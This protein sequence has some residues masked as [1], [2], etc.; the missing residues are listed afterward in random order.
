MKSELITEQQ[1][2]NAQE[3]YA[4]F[5]VD[6]NL[7]LKNLA[8][9]PISIHCWQGDDVAGFE[10][11]NDTNVDSSIQTT[12][13]YPGRARNI[14]E[15][16]KDFELALKLIPGKHRLNLHASYLENNGKAVARNEIDIKH[17]AG[18]ADWGKGK[19]AGI[20]FNPTFFGHPKAIDGFTLSHPNKAIRQFWIEHGI[21]CRKIAAAFGKEFGTTTVNNFWVPDGFKDIPVDRYSPRARLADSLDTIFKEEYSQDLCLDSVESKLFGVGLESFTVGSHEFY[22]GYAMSRGK[23]L[24]LDSGHFHPT[25]MISEK[26]SALMQFLP[27]LL[28]HVSR[29][30]RWDSD[31]VII[32][33]DELIEIA[34]EI[35]RSGKIKNIHIG[36]DFFDASINRIAAWVIGTRNMIKALLYALLE[37]NQLLIE[38]ENSFDYTSRLA[39][40]EESKT[41]PFNVIWNYYCQQAE[42][43]VG[44]EWLNTVKTYEK[45]ILSKRD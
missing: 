23:M 4:N 45:E 34:C 24:C 29:P 36:L 33:N 9:I 17:F 40:K 3:Q 14:E 1:Y 20:D 28:L 10:N 16:R 42:A 25:E 39:L 7:A 26:I 5:G 37:P 35:I 30:V 31:H 2:Q 11:R 22:M 12:G 15:L 6:T 8:S 43:P 19:I 21:A 38:K 32:L 13:D 41:M 18:W 44:I 27:E